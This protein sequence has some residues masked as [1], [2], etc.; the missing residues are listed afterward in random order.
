MTLNDLQGLPRALRW[1]GLWFDSFTLSL[2]TYLF[3]DWSS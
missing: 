2:E 3:D 1:S